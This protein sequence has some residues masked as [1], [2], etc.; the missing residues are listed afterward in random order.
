MRNIDAIRAM[1]IEQVAEF[2]ATVS[3]CCRATEHNW[4]SCSEE[5]CPLS[6]A[7]GT[8]CNVE[9]ITAWL[10]SEIKED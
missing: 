3:S 10:N 9:S 8:Y 5:G 2:I 6:N 7:P 1:P 4:S